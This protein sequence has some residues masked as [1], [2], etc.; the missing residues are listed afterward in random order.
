M[1]GG[2]HNN[3]NIFHKGAELP[4]H[5]DHLNCWILWAT[6]PACRNSPVRNRTCFQCPSL[7]ERERHTHT[8]RWRSWV[9][10]RV[11]HLRPL[12]SSRQR[13]PTSAF[14][15]SGSVP[16]GCMFCAMTMRARRSEVASM[17]ALRLQGAA[18]RRAK[19]LS[20]M[21]RETDI[22]LSLFI[23]DCTGAAKC[24]VQHYSKA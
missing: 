20:A 14:G 16:L 6:A 8:R 22:S 24:D 7:G 2:S 23:R 4:M 12:E 21:T 15:S 17:L 10:S 9:S 19:H 13:L 18:E 11:R 3:R 1:C 5:E